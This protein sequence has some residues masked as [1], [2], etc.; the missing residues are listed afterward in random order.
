MT[1]TAITDVYDAFVTFVGG[2]LTSY[3]RLANAYSV[4]DNPSPVLKR[5]YGVKVGPGQNSRRFVGGL[6][7]TSRVF[8]IILTAE[9]AA[10]EGNVT[11]A[12]AAELSI[13]E[14][15]QAL[16]KGVCTNSTLATKTTNV[17]WSQDS[18]VQ[19]IAG[20]RFKYLAIEVGFTAE[21]VETN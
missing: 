16:I 12:R 5:G 19:F 8:T 9:M 7:S 10:V 14:D 13:L 21:Y 18:G 6:H 15:V 1:G 3:K 4:A 2:T 20:D 11:Q 17:Q